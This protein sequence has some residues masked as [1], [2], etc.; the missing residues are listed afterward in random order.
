MQVGTHTLPLQ[1]DINEFFLKHQ[2]LSIITVKNF[3]AIEKVENIHKHPTTGNY[4]DH[5]KRI[6]WTF[7]NDAQEEYSLTKIDY[8]CEGREADHIVI[9]FT[10]K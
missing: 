2:C 7:Y 3:K 9:I 8:K 10:N 5:I 6:F 4:I 1:K